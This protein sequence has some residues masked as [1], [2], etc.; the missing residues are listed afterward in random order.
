MSNAILDYPARRY[1]PDWQVSARPTIAD[2]AI[3]SDTTH[4]PEQNISLSDYPNLR[5][6]PC[7]GAAGFRP[8]ATHQSW[9]CRLT[10]PYARTSRPGGDLPIMINSTPSRRDHHAWR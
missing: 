2:E 8:D 4:A 9:P 10:P 7:R 5:A 1:A 6:L 3:Y